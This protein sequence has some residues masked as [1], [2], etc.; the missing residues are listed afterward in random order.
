MYG[1]Y[2][3]RVQCLE[4]VQASPLVSTSSRSVNA[5]PIN[6]KKI[7]M[8]VRVFKPLLYNISVQTTGVRCLVRPLAVNRK[9]TVGGGAVH[10]GF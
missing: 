9:V 1:C 2:G 3:L 4:M 8:E 7:L 5:A 10:A 6:A